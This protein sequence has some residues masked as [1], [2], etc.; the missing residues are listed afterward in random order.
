MNENDK[1]N[2]LWTTDNKDTIFNMLSMYVINSKNRGWWKHINV[3]LWGAFCSTF[4]RFLTSIIIN[5]GITVRYM[6]APLTE[7]LKNGEKILSI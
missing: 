6:G 4:R 3:I 1:L 5:L 2:I 7:C